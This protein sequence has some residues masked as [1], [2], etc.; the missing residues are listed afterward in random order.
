MSDSKQPKLEIQISSPQ[1]LVRRMDQQ[2]ELVERLLAEADAAHALVPINFTNSLGMTM[3]WCPP[4]EF[5]MGSPESEEGRNQN[6]NQVLVRISKGF[7]MASTPVTQGQWQALMHSN[8][9]RFQASKALPVE[10]VDWDDAKAFCNKLNSVEK[11]P[12][13]YI[14]SLPSEAQ[15][16]Y[17]CRAGTHSVYS[18]RSLDEL[19]WYERNSGGHTHEVGRKN[20]NAWGIHDMH[21]NVWEWCADWWETHLS[22]GSDPMGAVS[23]SMRVVRGASWRD[24]EHDCRSAYRI[25]GVAGFLQRSIGFRVAAIPVR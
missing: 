22:G 25:W 5:L 15:W 2:L 9:S 14:Y 4:G 19:G 18:G 16:E 10:E 21:G 1:A 23:E 17:S 7:W 8:P 3:I 13:G 6:E 20:A 12:S 11:P 24:G